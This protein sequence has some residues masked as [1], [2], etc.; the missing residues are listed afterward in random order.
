MILKRLSNGLHISKNAVLC[1]P[2]M[3]VQPI[4]M[5]QQCGSRDADTWQS[6]VGNPEVPQ[7]EGVVRISCHQGRSGYYLG[8]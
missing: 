8:L 2:K 4:Q 7:E 6:V 5:D 3:L 1:K